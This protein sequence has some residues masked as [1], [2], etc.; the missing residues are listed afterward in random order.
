MII[1]GSYDFS[2]FP[3]S[4]LFSGKLNPKYWCRILL[5]RIGG[6][7]GGG[8]GAVHTMSL[9]GLLT[10]QTLIFFIWNVICPPPILGLTGEYLEG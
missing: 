1:S 3:Q 7:G 4:Y 6:E 2:L 5:S 8:G 10:G 9:F